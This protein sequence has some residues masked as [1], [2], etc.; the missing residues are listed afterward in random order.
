M[1]QV[2]LCGHCGMDTVIRNPSGFCDHLYY[3]ENCKWCKEKLKPPFDCP[4]CKAKKTV[5]VAWHK[6]HL[7]CTE[8]KQ[9]WSPE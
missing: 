7:T 6:E 5:V 8:C 3:P 4:K 2:R 1:S 9:I